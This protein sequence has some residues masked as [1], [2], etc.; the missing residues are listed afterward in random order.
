[1]IL[2]A[3]I[4][5]LL[6]ALLAGCTLLPADQEPP[7]TA[8]TEPAAK[9]TPAE[10]QKVGEFSPEALYLLTAGEI[11]G[12]RGE[13]GQALGFYLEAARQT[14]DAGVA[15]RAARIGLLARALP[16]TLEAAQIWA[17]ADPTS[18]DARQVL[19]I[20]LLRSGQPEQALEQLEQMLTASGGESGQQF[21]VIA[22]LLSREPNGAQVVQLMQQLV[23]RHKDNPEAHFA[24]SELA[25]RQGQPAVARSAVEEALRLRPEWSDAINL[26]ARVLVQ[27]GE[28]DAAVAYLQE[29]LSRHPEEDDLRMTYARLLVQL[30]RVDDARKAFRELVRR[31][32]DNADAVFALG[33]LSLQA[34]LND[35]AAKL[36]ERLLDLDGSTTTRAQ[37]YLG[38]MAELNGDYQKAVDWYSSVRG[39]PNFHDAQLRIAVALA[40]LGEVDQAREHLHGLASNNPA[41]QSRLYQVEGEILVDAGRYEDALAVYN[42]ALT[43]QP[44]NHDLRYARA[45]LGERMDNLKLLE[46]DL[47]RIL[48]E[49]PENA[50]ALNALGYTLT[51]RTDRH[52][53]ALDLIQRAYALSPEDAAVTDSMGWVNFRLGNYQEAE[54][55]L[56]KALSLRDGDPEIAAHLG[57]L[58]WVQ[59]RRDEAQAIWDKALKSHPDDPI[60]EKTLKR[61]KGE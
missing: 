2:R 44:G 61:L 46:S 17:A 55:Y 57:E 38:Q 26:R 56:R 16:E 12:Q 27:A 59:N 35:E 50:Q 10:P 53:E 13:I 39:G 29:A 51:D 58:L 28:L 49:D 60:L 32:P 36:F 21:L 54:R 7:A 34:G 8:E 14:H 20:S 24:L 4:L 43:E 31:T 23:E 37:Y 47:R 25:L 22:A 18:A 48:T 42:Q 45:L 5:T 19:A 30:D 52:Q 15:E 33:L 41:V 1:M 40:R 11:A 9:S 3:F 6:A